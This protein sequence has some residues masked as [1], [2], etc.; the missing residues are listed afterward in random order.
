MPSALPGIDW[1]QAWF[2]PYRVLGQ[3]VAADVAAGQSVAQALNR[4]G[5][6]R[7]GAQSPR[8]VPARA[9]GSEAYEAFV[10]RSASVPTRDNVHDFFNGLVW[11]RFNALKRRVNLLHA[12]ELRRQGAAS[13]RGAA[14]DS[15]TLFDENGALLV[16]P[17]ALT[18]ALVQRDWRE[19]FID[20]RSL[21]CDAQLTIVGHALLEK[22]IQPRKAITAHVWLS[23]GGPLPSLPDPSERPFAPLP[24][25]GV[26]GWWP[27]NEDPSFYDD[28]AVF[29]PAGSPR[30]TD[31]ARPCRS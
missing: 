4:H 8:F 5:S 3:A 14:R 24:V 29:R 16:A 9:Q 19:L 23:V 31:S 12:A 27:D 15:L 11:L 18:R 30:S 2:A 1:Q 22:L 6:A 25:L 21:W 28:A 20:R 10:A 26:P 17:P 7:G 13:P